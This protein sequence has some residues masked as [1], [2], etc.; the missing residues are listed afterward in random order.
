MKRRVIEHKV[1]DEYCKV[2]R[3]YYT[4]EE[5]VPTMFGG[6]KYKTLRHAECYGHDVYHTTTTFKSA[7]AANEMIDNLNKGT[8]RDVTISKVI[9]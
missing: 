5:L 2:G 9:A 1:Y 8:P 6:E 3:T 7:D 4:I